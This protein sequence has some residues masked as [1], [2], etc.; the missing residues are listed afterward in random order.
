MGRLSQATPVSTATRG[1]TLLRALAPLQRKCAACDRD[2]DVTL[3][4]K[5]VARAAR[6]PGSIPRTVREVVETQ[7]GSPL[8]PETRDFFEPRLS[9]DFSRVRVHAGER[10]AEA[11]RAVNARAFTMGSH[12]VFGQGEF[13]PGTSAGRKLLAHELVHVVQQG[14]GSPIPSGVSRVDDA[15][16]RE[17][18]QVSE[19]LVGS[20]T[21]MRG[22]GVSAPGPFA[23]GPASNAPTNAVQRAV[24][25]DEDGCRDEEMGRS[26]DPTAEGLTAGSVSRP[27]TPVTAT[28]PSPARRPVPSARPRASGALPLVPTPQ[29]SSRVQPPVRSVGALQLGASATF[30]V[31][32]GFLQG[33]PGYTPP[34]GLLAQQQ[35]ASGAATGTELAEGTALGT[36]LAEGTALGTELAEGTLV[37]AE[38]VEGGLTTAQ[39]LAGAA[40]TLTEA[41]ILAAPAEATNPI[42]W[43]IGGVVVVTIGVLIVGAWALSR[44]APTATQPQ[45]QPQPRPR[46]VQAPVETSDRRR[47]DRRRQTEQLDTSLHPELEERRREDPCGFDYPSMP[48]CEDLPASFRHDN[49]EDA[50]QE[51]IRDLG[52]DAQGRTFSS[53][54]VEPSTQHDYGRHQTWWSDD[55]HI[56]VSVGCTTC[57]ENRVIGSAAPGMP[58]AMIAFPRERCGVLNVEQF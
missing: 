14:S 26:V 40:A 55:R 12:V 51:A 53:R 13:A 58:P 44:S 52:P 49:F 28:A 32:P 56:K 48:K 27:R 2:E 29:V 24:V 45:P 46:P 5:R 54:G 37:T 25:C 20:G 36:E 15:P 6:D 9:W 31:T 23:Q 57:C 8:D 16:E 50:L 7:A 22:S 17:A 38:V 41:E 1:P 21:S 47:R 34:A 43:I 18:E 11:A 30:M 4:R 19:K 33:A 3:Q 42:G 35:L 10:A 39:A